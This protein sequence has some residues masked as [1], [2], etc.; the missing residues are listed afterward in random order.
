MEKI[1]AKNREEW[2]AWL[3]QNHGQVKEIY[4]VYYKKNTGKPSITYEE[5]V[6]EAL[7]FGWIDGVRKSLDEESYLMRFTPRRPGSIWSKVNRERIEAAIRDEKMT[8][9][10]MR[11]VEAAQKSGQWEVAYRMK[12]KQEIPEDFTEALMQHPVAWENFN[13]F[14]N[15][16]QFTFITRIAGI[17]GI[18][19]RAEKIRKAVELCAKNLQPY[20]P[21]RKPR[22]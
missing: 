17:K 21:D 3:A 5:S 13:Q 16:V 2:R 6:E 19:L 10:G 7:C 20:G 9:A 22:F 18:A 11:A 1:Y 15:S 12:D 8:P 4:V 14:S